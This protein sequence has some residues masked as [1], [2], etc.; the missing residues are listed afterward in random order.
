VQV[1]F[2]ID[3]AID[4]GLEH[5]AAS[6]LGHTRDMLEAVLLYILFHLSLV[7]P[8]LLLLLPPG[9]EGLC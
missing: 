7:L 8:L 2:A 6:C 1:S 4:L 3:A 5:S 9:E